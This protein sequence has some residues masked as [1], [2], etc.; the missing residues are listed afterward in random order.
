MEFRELEEKNNTN[1]ELDSIEELDNIKELDNKVKKEMGINKDNSKQ[2]EHFE[3]KKEEQN[4]E[5]AAFQ[6]LENANVAIKQFISELNDS[7]STENQGYFLLYYYGFLQA[8]INQQNTIMYL[9]RLKKGKNL[10]LPPN[11]KRI[12]KIKRQSIGHL[13]DLYA[14][15]TEKYEYITDTYVTSD[16]KFYYIILNDEKN[17]DDIVYF[18]PVNIAEHNRKFVKATLEDIGLDNFI[19]TVSEC[20]KELL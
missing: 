5:L 20:Y 18:D 16:S 8:L 17:C 19:K 10:K 2:L 9:Y 13:P 1:E 14:E 11:L 15:G 4:A 3:E 6:I 12:R 7:I